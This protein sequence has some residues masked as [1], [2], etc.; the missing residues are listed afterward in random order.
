[1]NGLFSAQ[2][3][4]LYIQNKEDMVKYIYQREN[5]TDF[6]WN[7]KKISLLLA[8][9]RNLQGRLLEKMTSLGDGIVEMMLDAT[10]HRKQRH[11]GLA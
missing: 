5:W 1:M 9:V 11:Y 8:Q 3:V 6:S 10:Q 4:S 7:D 2:V